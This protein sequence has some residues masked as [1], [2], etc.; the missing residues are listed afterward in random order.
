MQLLPLDPKS[1]SISS[2]DRD[3]LRDLFTYL[4]YVSSHEVKRMTRS[5]NIPSADMKRLAKLLGIAPPGKDDW[6]YKQQH[7]ID[8][9]DEL[10][11]RL[12]LVFY[13]LKGEYRGYTSSQP[14]FINNYITISEKNL[15]KFNQLSPVEQEKRILDTLIHA[16]SLYDYGDHSYNEFYKVSLLGRLDTFDNWGSATGLMPTLKFPKIRLFL[17]D[18]LKELPAGEWFSTASL[19]AYLKTNHPYFLIPK[20]LPPKSR[21]G[22]QSGRYD[23]FH[24]GKNYWENGNT[25]PPDAP[26]AFE[27]VEGRYIERFLEYIPLVMRFVD[28]AY[29]PKPYKGLLP[30]RG[31]LKAFRINERFKLLMSGQDS[32]PKV[33]VQPNFDVIIESDFYPAAL[34]SQISALGEQVSSPNNGQGA[35]VGIFLLTKTAV[36]TAYVQNP[37]LDVIALLKNL[38]G[39]DLPTNVKIELEEWAGHA[40]QFTLYDGFALLEMADD[41]PADAQQYLAE[42]IAPDLNL[43]RKSQTVYATL[44]TLGYAPVRVIHP[45]GEF[46]LLTEPSQSR[47]PK[48]SEKAEVTISQ[49]RVQ[50]IVTISYQFPESES[51]QA[52][53]KML[54][55]LR[56]PFQADPVTYIVTIQQNQQKKFDEAVKKLASAFVLEIE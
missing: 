34:I 47:F 19:I 54:A 9:I 49:V 44:E 51:F 20:K 6:M 26:D 29:D 38:S 21:R 45:T 55:E 22:H 53:Q 52:L 3:L 35:Y 13:D 36:A 5:N 41:L 12:D 28:V 27:R 37:D 56:C 7:W 23:N 18:L 43:V 8:F 48:E 25:V 2:N 39:R 1:L 10:A 42:R 46:A 24:E 32:A 4:D 15:Q 30:S 16:K 31:Q 40:D 14:S 33:T 17:F 50:K 11:L